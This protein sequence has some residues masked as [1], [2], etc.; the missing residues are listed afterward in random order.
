MQDTAE[1]N[2][3]VEF[4]THVTS[5]GL[6]QYRRKV[7]IRKSVKA[8]LIFP[9]GRVA[10][11]LKRGRY[12]DRIGAGAPIFMA[13]ILE[14]LAAE[15]LELA[16]NAAKDNRK[17]RINPRHIQLAIR[18]DQEL[19]QLLHDVVIPEGGVLPHIHSNLVPSDKQKN[20]TPNDNQND[21]DRNEGEE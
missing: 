7:P 6:N 11:L 20:K 18:N 8:G 5:S 16:G 17:K 2:E 9:V 14:Y 1:R 19:S 15:V 12:S 21:G 3:Q 10:R 4:T 13:A